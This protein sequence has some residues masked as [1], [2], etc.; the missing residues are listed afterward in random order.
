MTI[1]PKKEIKS[2]APLKIPGDKSITHRAIILGAISQGT[3]EIINFLDSEDCR[4]TIECFKKMGVGF[5]QSGDLLRIR[6]VGLHGLQKPKDIL[7]VGNSGTTM[8]LLMGLLAAQKFDAVLDGD[9]SIRRRPMNRVA[10]PLQKMGANIKTREGLAPIEIFGNSKLQGIN[11][12]MPVLSAQVKSAVMLAALYAEGETRIMEKEA[13]LTRDHTELMLNF[14][15]GDIKT[16]GCEITIKPVKEIYAKEIE[17]PSDLSSAAYF[18]ALGLL[19][20]GGI[21]LKNVGLN[22]TRSGI[23]DAF[24]SMGANIIIKNKQK[25]GAELV[26][27][28]EIYESRAD[29]RGID[30]DGRLAARMIDDIP[31]LAVCACL[32]RGTTIIRGAQELALKES[33]RLAVLACELQKMGADISQTKD[34]LIIKGTAITTKPATGNNAE[35]LKGATLNSHKD[36][37]MAMSFAIAASLADNP[38]RISEADCINTSFPNFFNILKNI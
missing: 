31:I 28:I 12:Q 26:G 4:A 37:R 19:L 17:I 23:L 21:I 18:I 34:G 14:F 38:S 13:C 32:A 36:H 7:Y 22:P 24:I 15:G 35:K 11:Y 27:D 2:K 5:E 9:G 30:I 8:R 25:I 33:N 16:N 3:T 29:L 20:Q 10:I 6:G 1:Y